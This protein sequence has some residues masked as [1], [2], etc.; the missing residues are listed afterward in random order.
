MLVCEHAKL[1]VIC[2]LDCGGRTTPCEFGRDICCC[3]CGNKDVCKDACTDAKV[4][5]WMLKIPEM[6]CKGVDRRLYNWARERALGF[7]VKPDVIYADITVTMQR[8]AF[9]A[10]VNTGRYR[11]GFGKTAFDAL[12]N[13]A[14]IIDNGER[15]S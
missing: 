6:T 8:G 5:G 9:M 12:H 11:A 14:D 13:L 1:D 10:E 4:A 2:N 7:G 15:R 3:F